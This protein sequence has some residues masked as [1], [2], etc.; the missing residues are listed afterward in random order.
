LKNVNILRISNFTFKKYI[1]FQKSLMKRALLCLTLLMPVY[2]LS[3]QVDIF[4]ESFDEP[5]GSTTGSST[6]GINWSTSCPTCTTGGQF[7]QVNNGVMDGM[8]T[9]GVATWITDPIDISNCA[10]ITVSFDYAGDPFPGS[11]NLESYDECNSC[12]GDINFP[13]GPDCA[14]CWDFMAFFVNIDNV[15]NEIGVIG[16]GINETNYFF[17]FTSPCLNGALEAILEVRTQTW[18]ADENM[19]FDNVLLVCNTAGSGGDLIVANPATD[20][21]EGDDLTLSAPP[22]MNSYSWSGPAGSSSSQNWI[23]N[24]LDISDSGNYFLTV[25]D[26]NGCSVTDDIMINVSDGPSAVISG[27][28][29]LCLGQCLD[30]AFN[31]S[32]GVSPYNVD[33]EISVDPFTVPFTIPSV[34]IIDTVT[35]CADAAGLIPEYDAATNTI[36][37]P[38]I[39]G[40]TAS[41]TLQGITDSAGCDG[42]VDPTPVSL[43]LVDPPVAQT[44][45]DLEACDS[46]GNGVEDFDLSSLESIING[47]GNEDVHFY[48]DMTL[49]NEIF[50]PYTSSGSII[51]ATIENADCASEPISFE[52]VVLSS[53]VI[54]PLPDQNECNEFVLPLINGSN[55]TGNEAYYTG[56][57]GTG[58]VFYSGQS[59]TNSGTLYIYDENGICADEVSFF[60]NIFPGPDIFPAGDI[61]VCDY[62][63]LPLINGVNLTGNEAY[64]TGPNGSGTSYLPG[65]IVNTDLTLNMYDGTSGCDDEES[66]DIAVLVSPSI[67]PQNDVIVCNAFTLPPITGQNLTGGQAYYLSSDG[68]GISYQPGDLIDFS[69][70]IYIY[71][72]NINCAD[73]TSFDLII[74]SGPILATVSDTSV[75]EP[76]ILPLIE[77]EGL[78]GNE[79]YYS[80][81]QASGDIYFPGDTIFSDQNLYIFDGAPECSDEVSFNVSVGEGLTAGIG[82]S[83]TICDG[84]VIDLF[85]FIT[86][87]DT[88][89]TFLDPSNTGGLAGTSFDGTG[90]AGINVGIFYVL[91]NAG[92]CPNDT[93]VVEIQVVSELQAGS[94]TIVQ[95]CAGGLINLTD[96]LNGGDPGG[97]FDDLDNTNFLNGTMLFL[98]SLDSGNY[99]FNYTVGDGLVCPEYSSVIE[100]DYQPVPEFINNTDTVFACAF[101]I[102]PAINGNYLNGSEAYYL[103]AGGNGTAY[104]LVS[105]ASF[106]PEGIAT[107]MTSP[108]LQA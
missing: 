75:C 50:S 45:N 56:P 62:Y 25:V 74:T 36:H 65:D 91:D 66:F 80:G 57:N 73:E 72:S 34:E 59:I 44:P 102:L 18:A 19:T 89:G 60:I 15:S 107:C 77:G 99:H 78:T 42:T 103:E 28:G 108:N 92:A 54:I 26:G 6:E 1:V 96:F 83:T 51:Y 37:V 29:N 43:T 67:D 14:F 70:I 11:G 31:I 95:I 82:S 100:I 94:D 61:L 24:N 33:M 53:P 71:D 23:I 84:A 10:T 39:T 69:A 27:G 55:L 68:N 8:N 101:Y 30:I 3:G 32:G 17:E 9:D 88:G 85:D 79:A 93:S 20:L 97:T 76:F 105:L 13:T 22:G 5:T 49:V 52:L 35:I 106:N 41:V 12:A 21:C 81:A 98:D 86:N 63:E 4:T 48:S 46:D 64:Y 40:I 90:L 104:N 7:F 47:G 2:F 16:T 87:E 58:Q 38:Q